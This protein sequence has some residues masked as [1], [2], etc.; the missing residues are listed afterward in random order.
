MLPKIEGTLLPGL[1]WGEISFDEVL[2]QYEAA[3]ITL[4]RSPAGQLY[5]TWWNDADDVI[6]RWVCLRMTKQRLRAVLSDEMKPRKAMA[7]PEDGYLLVVDI[8]LETDRPG[9]H[10][11][12][13]LRRSAAGYVAPP[14]SY[15]ENPDAGRL[16]DGECHVNVQSAHRRRPSGRW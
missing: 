12:N 3:C 16:V 5:L 10:R 8:D 1:P 6:E 14:R 15:P 13:H 7:N 11:Q 9:P 2:D 4:Q